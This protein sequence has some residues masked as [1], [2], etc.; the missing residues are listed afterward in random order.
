MTGDRHVSAHFL[1]VATRRHGIRMAG[2]Y[3]TLLPARYVVLEINVASRMFRSVIIPDVA[4]GTVL[5]RV[6]RA[7]KK[8]RI[9]G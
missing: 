4:G 5:V 6:G 8:C 7:P 9:P 3:N 1:L 2:N